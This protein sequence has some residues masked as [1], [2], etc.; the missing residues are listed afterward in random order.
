MTSDAASAAAGTQS[1]GHLSTIS[2]F[3]PEM[4]IFG[5]KFLSIYRQYF[6]I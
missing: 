3:S 5:A 1:V 2:V 4:Q 6:L